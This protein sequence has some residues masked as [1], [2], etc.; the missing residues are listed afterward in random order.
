MTYTAAL[1]LCTILHKIASQDA[2][3]CKPKA[4][5][6]FAVPI[7]LS[8]SPTLEL[9]DF[10]P[11]C[12]GQCHCPLESHYCNKLSIFHYFNTLMSVDYQCHV[13][14]NEENQFRQLYHLYLIDKT[15][16]RKGETNF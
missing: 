13:L 3:H 1:A 9:H 10:Y 16:E 14:L 6:F 7:F 11:D 15:V 5:I 4:V 2:L 12:S 8:E